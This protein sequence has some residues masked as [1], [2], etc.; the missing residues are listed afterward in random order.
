MKALTNSLKYSEH[1]VSLE[2]GGNRL[3]SM[4]VSQIFK[5]LNENKNLAYKL[6]NIDLSENHIGKSQII[7]LVDFL[8]DPKCNLEDLNLYGNLL[9][10]ENIITICDTIANYV[11]YKLTNLNLGKN[12]IT[13]S[14][15]VKF[16]VTCC[17][18]I[19]SFSICFSQ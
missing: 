2:F 12:N 17:I 4:G 8:K 11:E 15:S 19:N 5:T 3:S 7:N 13:D 9:G 18:V 16:H 14:C 6:R 1:L 10:D